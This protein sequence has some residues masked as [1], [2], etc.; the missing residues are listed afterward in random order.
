ME[1]VDRIRFILQNIGDIDRDA[2]NDV[3]AMSEEELVIFGQR[4]W[5][6]TKRLGKAF[7]PVKVRLREL[8]LTRAN[9][10]LGAQR[11]EAIDG[12]HVIVSIP[13]GTMVMR[14]D[15]DMEKVQSVLGDKF[16][17]VFETVTTFRPRKDMQDQVVG[18]AADELA[19]VMSVVDMADPTPK[20]AFKD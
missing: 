18:W 1:I 14:K 13:A 19:A 7:E 11:F 6:L 20:V 15:A 2:L 9:G 3:P 12:S 10:A 4:V 17:T 8:A 16:D 5:W